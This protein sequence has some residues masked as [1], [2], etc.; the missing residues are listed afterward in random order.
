MIK[1]PDGS[2]HVIGEHLVG[3]RREVINGSQG[4]IFGKVGMNG[5][6]PFLELGL[7]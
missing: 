6:E 3:G 2:L 4:S 7:P 5:D 1:M